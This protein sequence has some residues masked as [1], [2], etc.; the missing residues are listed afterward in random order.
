MASQA[1]SEA[2]ATSCSDTDGFSSAHSDD[3]GSTALD[4]EGAEGSEGAGGQQGVGS[5]PAGRQQQQQRQRQPRHGAGTDSDDDSE[6]S[7]ASDYHD[8]EQHGHGG[9][10]HPQRSG[11]DEESHRCAGVWSLARLLEGCGQ[12]RAGGLL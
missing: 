8:A 2:A 12:G 1:G 5:P 7:A 6:S 11:E 4:E 9:H 3:G 10:S